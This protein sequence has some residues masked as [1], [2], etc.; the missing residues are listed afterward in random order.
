ML[1]MSLAVLDIRID[2]VNFIL[3]HNNS[4]N[5][6]IANNFNEY[7]SIV[8]FFS[9][10]ITENNDLIMD[11]NK[12]PSHSHKAKAQ[13]AF[14][15]ISTNQFVTIIQKPVNNLYLC[16]L[17]VNDYDSVSLQINIPPPKQAS[18]FGYLS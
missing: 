15:A 4:N 10:T 6:N 9:V 5:N 1:I 12:L 11:H 3:F 18:F 16:A 14:W 2:T 7:N 13:H 8:A 17:N